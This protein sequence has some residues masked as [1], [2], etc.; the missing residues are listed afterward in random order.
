[1]IAVRD[2]ESYIIFRLSRVL[3]TTITDYI[4]GSRDIN[5]SDIADGDEGIADPDSASHGASVADVGGLAANVLQELD[6]MRRVL[7]APPLDAT[8]ADLRKALGQVQLAYTR[9]RQD[10]NGVRTEYNKLQN[11]LAPRTRAR[12]L[13]A[14]QSGPL[15]TAVINVA[16]KYALLYH[17]WVPSGIFPLREYPANFDFNHPRRYQDN[18][19]RI[20]AYAAEIYLMLPIALQTQATK[21]EQFEYIFTSTVNTER[22][23]ILKP[24]KDS[25]ALLFS[26][27]ISALDPV[28]LGDRKKCVD[29]PVFLSLL[30]R[31]PTNPD[32]QYTSLA[33]ILFQDPN[34][35]D[36]QGLFKNKV[37]TQM[38]CVLFDGK[39]VLTGKKRGGPPGRGRKLGATTMTEGMIAACCT[40]AR[41]LLSGDDEF[42]SIG[43]QT[44]IQ[45]EKDFEYYVELLRKPT[46]KEW[47]LGVLAHFNDAVFGADRKAS[48]QQVTDINNADDT[49]GPTGGQ[50]RSWEDDIMDQLGGIGVDNGAN[51]NISA[52]KSASSA[53]NLVPS[54]FNHPIQP[55]VNLNFPNQPTIAMNPLSVVVAAQ[56]P[57]D[58][59]SISGSGNRAQAHAAIPNLGPVQAQN[60]HIPFANLSLA[61]GQNSQ[62]LG[63]VSATLN[64]NTTP[65]VMIPALVSVPSKAP[66]SKKGKKPDHAQANAE[67]VTGVPVAETL[68]PAC[69][70][71][72]FPLVAH[73]HAIV[74]ARCLPTLVAQPH[75]VVPARCSPTL[76]TQPHAV[77]P[78]RCLLKRPELT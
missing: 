45:Y 22:A 72:S 74:P 57:A 54:S 39:G 15:D 77:V 24:L 2:Q 9:I 63:S 4:S 40:F 19:T 76:V 28:A 11:Q 35:I 67:E 59:P 75:A 23:N 47:S 41:Y 36:T 58:M 62:P 14:A 33:P 13:K 53:L 8:V 66:Q 30:K 56:A 50:T 20:T 5:L 12:A 26:H 52:P 46:N 43:S 60:V 49:D 18:E 51:A 78:A 25:A 1:M 34:R 69:P 27:L 44:N 29:N 17:L 55:A 68:Q 70:M 71:Q 65:A 21:Y 16:K 38:A 48:R 3:Y 37:L 10:L 6:E 7:A 61:N 32:N 42:S 31:D 64:I 73:P